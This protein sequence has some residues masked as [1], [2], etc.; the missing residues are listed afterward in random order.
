MQS[1]ALTFSTFWEGLVWHPTVKDLF[2]CLVEM[3]K[4]LIDDMV[5]AH[6]INIQI[7]QA[8]LDAT[9]GTELAAEVLVVKFHIY[10]FEHYK[11]EEKCV[12][13]LNG[14]L[15]F[16]ESPHALRNPKVR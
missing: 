9:A 8:R 6:F 15:F 5:R 10:L 11:C 4:L 7:P 1:K 16:A 3:F 12:V 14:E 13:E 2:F